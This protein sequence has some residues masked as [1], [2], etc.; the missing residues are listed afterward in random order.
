MWKAQLD[1]ELTQL[2]DL[3]AKMKVVE[4]K[5]ETFAKN[6]LQIVRIQTIPGVGRKTAEAL[7][8]AKLA[9]IAWAMMRDET[10]WDSIKL[11]PEMDP[12]DVQL[13]VKRSKVRPAG[14]LHSGPP[15]YQ[16]PSGKRTKKTKR[17]GSPRRAPVK[18]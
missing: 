9:V 2:D 12:E 1:L 14:E 18:T 10:N 8:A 13:K 11:L 4:D 5:L 6:N 17:G 3:T 7:V 16:R 15:Q